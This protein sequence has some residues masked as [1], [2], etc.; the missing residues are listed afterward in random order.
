MNTA[1]V[2]F[3]AAIT[4]LCVN[5]LLKFARLQYF[6]WFVSCMSR[7]KRVYLLRTYLSSLQLMLYAVLLSYNDSPYTILV[8]IIFSGPFMLG[9]FDNY[10]A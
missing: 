6:P 4:S 10:N 5:F 8:Q 1:D 7:F 2:G 3:V 9:Y